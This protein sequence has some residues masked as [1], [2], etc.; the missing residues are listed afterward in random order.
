M[1]FSIFFEHFVPFVVKYFTWHRSTQIAT[2]QT[3]YISKTENLT[4]RPFFVLF[5]VKSSVYLLSFLLHAL[6]V[7]HGKKKIF[8]V[9]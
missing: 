6:H 2:N 3:S 7:L 5:V 8:A 1:Y 9:V 4:K